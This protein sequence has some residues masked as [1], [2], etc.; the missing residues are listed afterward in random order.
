MIIRLWY[1]QSKKRPLNFWDA[2]TRYHLYLNT[3][4]KYE[5][6]LGAQGQESGSPFF[7]VSIEEIYALPAGYCFSPK[8]V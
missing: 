7:R 1:G 5:A 6:L 4:Q 2:E 8:L 3:Q